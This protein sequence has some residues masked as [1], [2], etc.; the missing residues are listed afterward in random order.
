M[1]EQKMYKTS[2]SLVK[3]D[4][5]FITKVSL[6]FGLGI[7]LTALITM[8]LPY[9]Y[10]SFGWLS[11]T[12]EGVSDVYNFDMMYYFFIGSAVLLLIEVIVMQF[13]VIR[14]GGLTL[15]PYILYCLTM[16][17]FLSFICMW[18]SWYLLGLSFGATS[19]VFITM[20]LVGFFSKGRLNVWA[21]IAIATL[22]GL[23][24]L[25]I[26]NWV[27]GSETLYWLISFG[28]LFVIMIF[29]AVDFQRVKIYQDQGA[30]SNKLALLCAFNLYY[31]FTYIFIQILKFVV[32]IYSRRR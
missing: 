15:F 10:Q 29:T 22:W 5:S 11:I 16:G 17:V 31:D 6:Y 12:S 24:I 13:T 18:V 28:L 27:I 19:I 4:S 23:L 1:E 30:T 8:G 7:L 20:G 25:S 2:E 26:I 21:Q 14:H 3:E 32:V 9:L